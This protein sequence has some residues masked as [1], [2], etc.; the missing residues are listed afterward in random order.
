ML[1]PVIDGKLAH[2]SGIAL[3]TDENESMLFVS[4]TGL[5]RILRIVSHPSGVYHTGVF[6]QFSGRFGPTIMAMN[7]DGRIFVA[8][9]DFTDCSKH[10]VTYILNQE[11][12][13]EE[14]L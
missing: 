14:A 12:I 5:N 2:P 9:Y 4:E 1:K 11:G 7:P 8:R 13:V 10:G 3:S 6:H